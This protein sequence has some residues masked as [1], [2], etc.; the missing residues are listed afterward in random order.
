MAE[1]EDTNIRLSAL[2]LAIT[3]LQGRDVA[4]NAE[5]TVIRTAREFEKYLTQGQVSPEIRAPFG[6]GTTTQL[7]EPGSTGPFPEKP[8]E[9]SPRNAS[10][11]AA[12]AQ[13]LSGRLSEF[14]DRYPHQAAGDLLDLVR[15][16]KDLTKYLLDSAAKSEAES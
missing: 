1:V 4:S 10:V 5:L 7:F 12:M 15:E 8:S 6:V 2:N 11:A 16:L 13:S 3:A 9:I 14:V